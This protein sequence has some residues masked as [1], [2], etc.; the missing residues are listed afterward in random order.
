MHVDARGNIYVLGR[1]FPSQQWPEN[2][3]GRDMV[4]MKF[5]NSGSLIWERTWVTP[6]DD[7]FKTFEEIGDELVTDAAGNIYLSGHTDDRNLFGAI[8]AVKLDAAGN[9]LW[10]DIYD[11]GTGD[12][13]WPAG[14]EIAPDGQSVYVGATARNE[15]DQSHYDFTVIR[16][17]AGGARTVNRYDAH[18]SAEVIGPIGDNRNVMDIDRAGNL[19]L[20]GAM[21]DAGFRP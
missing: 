12:A 21:Q 15:Q 9:E 16:Y 3:T 20:T 18:P 6:G 14:I 19:Y 7:D 5:T 8:I 4:L 11:P 1:T 10:H 13:D 2:D 17:A